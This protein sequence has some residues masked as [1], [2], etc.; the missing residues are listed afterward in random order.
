MKTFSFTVNGKKYNCIAD[1]EVGITITD[2]KHKIVTCVLCPTLAKNKKL[3]KERWKNILPNEEDLINEWKEIWKS[4]FSTKVPKDIRYHNLL[5]F[6]P[7]ETIPGS[8]DG[9]CPFGG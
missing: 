6:R 8:N 2:G 4:C 3:L 1:K 5:G 7:T 9:I